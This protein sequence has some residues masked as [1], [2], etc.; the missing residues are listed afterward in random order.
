MDLLAIWMR[1]LQVWNVEGWEGD[2]VAY[3]RLSG[4]LSTRLR[5]K[6]NT[7]AQYSYNLE[8]IGSVR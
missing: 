1:L 6:R 4:M 7:T 2:P 3:V 5:L 8:E